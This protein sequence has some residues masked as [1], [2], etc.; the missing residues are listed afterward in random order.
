MPNEP[1]P[2]VSFEYVLK[3]WMDDG[4]S[5]G[6]DDDMRPIYDNLCGLVKK[7]RLESSTNMT[8]PHDDASLSYAFDKCADA[9]D[10]ILH[11]PAKR[12]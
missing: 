4:D 9:L 5:Y 2:E 1:K 10:A 8:P 6:R 7:W 11:G 3:Q 12:D